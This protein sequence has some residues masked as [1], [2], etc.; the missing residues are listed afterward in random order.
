VRV[1]G[2]P[3]APVEPVPDEPPDP[4]AGAAATRGVPKLL[5]A[6]GLAAGAL[7]A[8]PLAPKL[9]GPED[10]LAAAPGPA[11]GIV[12]SVEP[13]AGSKSDPL[14]NEDDGGGPFEG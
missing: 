7:T 3:A 6:E 8:A 2:E 10:V 12:G 5:G 4:T 14:P 11:G 1:A 13:P 9:G